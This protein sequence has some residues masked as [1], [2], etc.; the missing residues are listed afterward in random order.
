MVLSVRDMM[1][2]PHEMTT[3]VLTLVLDGCCAGG[4][5]NPWFCCGVGDPFLW[6]EEQDLGALCIPT[7][8]LSSQL[9]PALLLSCC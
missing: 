7:R 2:S 6:D 3:L 5:Q 8:A 9:P 1:L 4:K